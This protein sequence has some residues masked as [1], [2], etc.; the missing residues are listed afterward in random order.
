MTTSVK[1]EEE[2][3]PLSNVTSEG[4]EKEKEAKELDT[5]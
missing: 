4:D 3:V 1:V 2:K 5:E